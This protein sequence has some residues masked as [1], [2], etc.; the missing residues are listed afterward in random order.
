MVQ[1]VVLQTG[2]GAV[3]TYVFVYQPVFKCT[4]AAPEQPELGVRIKSAVFD[5][6]AEEEILA[7]NPE[8]GDRGVRSEYGPDFVSQS[9]LDLLVSV[10]RKNPFAR[11]FYQTRVFL[12]CEALPWFNVKLRVERLGDLA[13]AV[14]RPGIDDD[15]LVSPAGAGQR[16]GEVGFLVER[17]DDDRETQAPHANRAPG[18]A[19]TKKHAALAR[20]H[21]DQASYCRLLQRWILSRWSRLHGLRFGWPRR[22]RV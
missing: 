18:S 7:W 12:C 13:G 9:R 22:L 17:D 5:P 10:E 4:R 15:D 1:Q 21:V 20:R 3:K 2:G 14:S 6:A 8:T 11:G 19:E 16:T